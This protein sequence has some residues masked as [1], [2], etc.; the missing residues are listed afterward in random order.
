[1][2]MIPK[3]L[4]FTKGK[5]KH[6][7]KLQSFELALRDAGIEK[8]NLV[9]VSSIIP[10]NCE[11]ISKEKGVQ[12]IT[13]GEI[14]YCVLAKNTSSKMRGAIGAAVGAALPKGHAFHGYISEY[15]FCDETEEQAKEHAEDLAATMLA[16][17]LGIPFDPQDDWNKRKHQYK[18]SG[19]NVESQSV[20]STTRVKE[21]DEYVTVVAAAVFL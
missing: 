15:L 13:P 3:K 8:C 4:F 5:G 1:M 16:T 11:I 18:M 9:S 19:Y 10:Q 17:T 21:G 20:A 12:C 6:R 7:H 2:K 14:T